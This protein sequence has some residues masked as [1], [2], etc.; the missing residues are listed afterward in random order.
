MY[1]LGSGNDSCYTANFFDTILAN[2][3][4]E[5]HAPN[6]YPEGMVR[7]FTFEEPSS[8]ETLGFQFFCTGRC[9]KLGLQSPSSIELWSDPK[10]EFSGT[11][12]PDPDPRE[13]QICLLGISDSNPYSCILMNGPQRTACLAN[14]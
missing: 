1:S 4:L 11:K 8:F 12:S 6:T 2:P 10:F 7:T 9:V 3:E 5:P 13:S 14:G